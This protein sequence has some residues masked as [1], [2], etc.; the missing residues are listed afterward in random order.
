[1]TTINRRTFL[2]VAGA[3][4]AAVA[5]GATG[6]VAGKGL[7]AGTGKKA[8]LSFKA[9]AGLPARPLPNYC[10]YV[11][12]GHLDLAARTG[13][14]T[15]TMYAGYPEAMSQSIWSG[16]TRLIRVSGIR[17]NGSVL[18]VEGSVADRSQLRSG[19]SPTFHIQIDRAAHTAQ[20]E[21]MGKAISLT[22]E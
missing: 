11:I 20:G 19:E 15:E 17:Q 16:F 5:V 22:L 8:T 10:T 14:V 13:T 3:S 18:Q 9:V 2:T 21:F 7:L 6:I 4:T 12:E 1:M